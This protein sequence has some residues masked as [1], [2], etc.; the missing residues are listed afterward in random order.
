MQ[1]LKYSSSEVSCGGIDSAMGLWER[2]GSVTMTKWKLHCS[3]RNSNGEMDATCFASRQ[4]NGLWDWCLPSIMGGHSR[5]YPSRPSV[6][7]CW[8]SMG[9]KQM[10]WEERE[11]ES[12]GGSLSLT[13]TSDENK[14]LRGEAWR[15]TWGSPIW[16]GSIMETRDRAL[17]VERW[18]RP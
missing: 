7:D 18:G 6:G 17:N 11:R 15:Q 8:T 3:W 5:S 1:Q 13:T 16:Y 10:R 12:Q 4:G 14:A 9:I 2:I